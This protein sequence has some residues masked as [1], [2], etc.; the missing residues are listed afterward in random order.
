MAFDIKSLTLGE[1]AKVEELS[2]QGIGVL[3]DEEKPKGLALAALAFVIKRRT[4]HPSFTWNQAQ[5]LT[6]DEA[7]TLLT[8]DEEDEVEGKDDSSGGSAKK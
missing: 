7:Y 4:G 8:G 6:A 2:G 1:I 3:E 5:A